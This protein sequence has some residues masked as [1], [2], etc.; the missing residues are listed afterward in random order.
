MT[1]ITA[2][3]I[4]DI[5]LIWL[6]QSEQSRGPLQVDYL[7][8][9]QNRARAQPACPDMEPAGML[10]HGPVSLSVDAPSSRTNGTRG[11]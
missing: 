11:A 4:N 8:P 1:L 3:A 5:I 9:Q 7:T 6:R 10:Q 2:E